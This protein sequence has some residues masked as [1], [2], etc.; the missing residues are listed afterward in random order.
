VPEGEIRGAGLP[1]SIKTYKKRIGPTSTKEKWKRGD[2]EEGRD[3]AVE[4]AST[5][6]DMVNKEFLL[7]LQEGASSKLVNGKQRHSFDPRRLPSG[8][9]RSKSWGG[10]ETNSPIEIRCKSS[11]GGDWGASFTPRETLGYPSPKIKS[12]RRK[13]GSNVKILLCNTAQRRDKESRWRKEKKE[14]RHFKPTPPNENVTDSIEGGKVGGRR[15]INFAWSTVFMEP[16]G[17]GANWQK[18][19]NNW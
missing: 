16:G 18:R 17:R 10:P 14:A 12:R 2:H 5:H 4:G 6:V 11:W 7:R 3:W 1:V 15:I 19:Q 9:R 8:S 13:K